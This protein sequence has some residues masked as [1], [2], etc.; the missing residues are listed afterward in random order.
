MMLQE[1]DMPTDVNYLKNKI[2]Y[3]YNLQKK[4][5]KNKMFAQLNRSQQLLW[6]RI[7]SEITMLSLRCYQS[8]KSK[9]ETALEA[10][11]YFMIAVEKGNEKAIDEL[12]NA[13]THTNHGMGRVNVS[14]SLEKSFHRGVCYLLGLNGYA[15]DWNKAYAL[16]HHAAINGHVKAQTQIALCYL[17]Y[18][19]FDARTSENRA[20]KWMNIASK[21]NNTFA[22][23]LVSYSHIFFQNSISSLTVTYLKQSASEGLVNAQYMLAR[24]YELGEGVEQS[25]NKAILWYQLAACQGSVDAQIALAQHYEKIKNIQQAAMW[26][27]KAAQNGNKLALNALKN[28]QNLFMRYHHAMLTQDIATLSNLLSISP[29]ILNSF[30]YFELEQSCSDTK[31]TEDLKATIHN[32]IQ[33]GLGNEQSTHLYVKILY[34][35]DKLET[36]HREIFCDAFYEFKHHVLSMINWGSVKKEDIEKLMTTVVDE[37]YFSGYDFTEKAALYL[38]RLI[39]RNLSLGKSINDMHLIK[40]CALIIVKAH[41]GKTH[42]ILY[43]DI[44]DKELMILISHCQSGKK[45]TSSELNSILKTSLIVSHHPNIK[46][47]SLLDGLCNHVNNMKKM[48]KSNTILVNLASYLEDNWLSVKE[49]NTQKA[50]FILNELREKASVLL[51]L[52]KSDSFFS[53]RQMSIKLIVTWL[54]RGDFNSLYAYVSKNSTPLNYHTS[55]SKPLAVGNT[56]D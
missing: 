8:L 12:F 21:K 24:L 50:R 7:N 2:D 27:R 16:I 41:L 54:N 36:T 51:K 28:S 18:E 37:W 44:T 46:L 25:I 23:F 17:N 35:F 53:I 30:I 48:L 31:L 29:K 1:I 39:Y 6:T 13:W 14:T 32:L 47:A 10:A 20:M 52:E 55:L 33:N 38:T 11:H 5:T 49:K 9:R 26:Y 45:V 4:I 40:Q 56:M 34:A 15:P 3:L 22:K 43:K 42:E 19:K